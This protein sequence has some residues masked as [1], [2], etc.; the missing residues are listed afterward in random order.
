V[1]IDIP[2]PEA[3]NEFL[4]REFP[5][6]SASGYRCIE[7]AAGLAVARW[8]YDPTTLRPGGL[9]SGATQFTLADVAFWFMTFTVLGLAPMAVTSELYIS[10]L[11]PAAGGDLI[12][13]CELLRAGKTAIKGTVRLWVD[14]AP[15]KPVSFVTGSYIQLK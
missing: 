13:R 15:D 9:I 8:P 14:G 10:Y 6:A 11:R 2:T 1:P 3:I 7:T 5:S 4:A 12:A